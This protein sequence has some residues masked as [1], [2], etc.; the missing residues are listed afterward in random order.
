MQTNGVNET[1]EIK[2]RGMCKTNYLREHPAGPLK[3]QLYKNCTGKTTKAAN[4]L[5][6]STFKTTEMYRTRMVN[7]DFQNNHIDQLTQKQHVKQ[8]PALTKMGPFQK[9]FHDLNMCVF[10]F[11]SH[12]QT[13]KVVHDWV[14]K[15][16]TNY[17]K[18]V[19]SDTV[20]K[21]VFGNKKAEVR[22]ACFRVL[23]YTSMVG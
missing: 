13:T 2:T 18:R 22:Q 1:I 3:K 12:G 10:E 15:L 5:T 20:S 23:Q 4:W 11:G 16:A 9:R 19:C 14:D 17:A 7:L 6:S 8:A 21:K